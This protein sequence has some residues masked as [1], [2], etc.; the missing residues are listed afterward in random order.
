MDIFYTTLQLKKDPVNPTDGANKRYVDAAVLGTSWA[1]VR[2]ATSGDLGGSLDSTGTVLTTGNLTDPSSVFDGIIPVNGNRVNVWQN[3]STALNG[4]YTV[5]NANG[6]GAWTLIR[7]TDA[8]TPSQFTTG[9]TVYVIEG[10]NYGGKELRFTSPPPEDMATGA[11]VFTLEPDASTRTRREVR[12]FTADGTS[13]TYNIQHTLGT[14]NPWVFFQDEFG[15]TLG[16]LWQ[17]DISDVSMN[18]IQAMTDV[19]LPSGLAVTVVLI[20]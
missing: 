12:T 18:T 15:G 17:A 3:T 7:T 19:P 2:V 4:L 11:K 8:Q 20:G 10:T 14:N 5:T 1:S 13:L 16:I 9:K 6:L